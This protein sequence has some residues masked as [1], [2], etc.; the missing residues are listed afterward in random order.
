M[1]P[2]HRRALK[3]I[4][5]C[6][7]PQMGGGRYHCND[8]DE[9]FWIYHGCRNRSCP[10][11]HGSRTAKWLA[12]R[13]VEMLPCHY[14]HVVATIPSEL[15][16]LFLKHQKVLYGILMKSAAGALKELAAEN[17]Y[18]GAEVGILA[19]LHTW[20]GKLH[21]HPHAHMLVTGG[22]VTADGSAWKEAPHDFLVPV[23]KLSPMISQRFAEELKKHH[24]DLHAL[25][26]PKIWKREWC[27]FIKPFGTGKDAVLR[28][29]ARY[30]FR[31]A[32]S[33]ARILSMDESHVTF[34]YKDNDTGS[35]ETE[36]LTGVE[37]LRRF[38]MHVL[39]KGFHKVRYYGL[40]SPVKRN[41]QAMARLLLLLTKP[42]TDE[43]VLIAD[44][45]E[46]VV[47]QGCSEEHGYRVR[48]PVCN[49]TDVL[50]IQELERG[51]SVMVT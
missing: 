30:V 40:W 28:Y 41:L 42:V 31:V 27:S 3:D 21:H 8:C 38:L 13:E 7:T 1:L 50:L 36:R 23:K 25:I 12:S 35:W 43:V 9:S 45:A 18:V 11:C 4:A 14:F 29:L 32:I 48:C 33:N 24:P 19:V 10:K 34:G 39:P 16:N 5:E 37:F 20:T 2:S 47:D 26:A 22:G 6:M 17:R 49:S 15:R 46:E 44:L 51:G